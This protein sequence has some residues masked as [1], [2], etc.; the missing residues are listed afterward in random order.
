MPEQPLL[1]ADRYLASMLWPDDD[2]IVAIAK[3]RKFTAE[4]ESRVRIDPSQPQAGAALG[5]IAF[6]SSVISI[7]LTIAASFFKPRTSDSKGGITATEKQ[8]EN[9]IVANRTA[10]KVGFDSVQQ[11][12]SL[13]STIPV[14]WARRQTLPAQASPPRPAGTYGGIRVNLGL[15]WSQLVTEKGSQML[16][17]VFLLG[18]GP[19]ANLDTRGFAIGDNSLGTYDIAD[20]SVREAVSRATIYANLVG[21]AINGTHGYY[22]RHPSSDPGNSIN[23]GGNTVFAIKDA[24]NTYQEHFCYSTKPSTSTVFGLYAHIPNKM[25]FRVN[26]RIRPTIRVTTKSFDNGEKFRVD[27]DDDPQALADHWK[28]RYHYSM[29]SGIE[30]TSTGSTYLNTGD[31]FTYRLDRRSDAETKFRFNNNNTDNKSSESDGEASCGDV[32]SAISSKQKS[33]DEALIIGE[34]YRCGSCLAVLISK[35]PSDVIFVSDSDTAPYEG[36]QTVYYVFRVVTAGRIGI[37]TD[38]KYFNP[39]YSGDRIDPPEWNRSS[40]LNKLKIPAKY[41]TCSSFPQL[42][43]CAIANLILARSSRIFE[44]GIK[45]TVGIRINGFINLRD[46]PSLVRI[47][48]NA[49]LNNEGKTYDKNAKIGITSFQSGTIQRNETRISFFRIWIRYGG[50]AWESLNATWGIRGS[51]EDSIFNSIRFEMKTV[52]RW[53]VRFEPVSSWEL[54]NIDEIKQPFCIISN[55]SGSTNRTMLNDGI[56]VE[57]NGYVKER[58]RTNFNISVLDTSN[59]IGIPKTDSKS[60]ID[61]WAMVAEGFPY[62]EIQCTAQSGPEH[63]IVY[64]NT[65][66]ENLADPT[67]D[68]IA[69][70]GLNIF[71]STEFNQL[72]Q[73]SAYV[74]GGT[75]ARRLLDSDVS[76]S[77]NLFPDVLREYLTN[78]IYGV[79]SAIGDNLVDFQSFFDAADW[80]QKRRY[81]YDAADATRVN[82]LQYAADIAAFHLLELSQRGGKFALSPAVVFPEDGPVPVKALFTAGNIVEGT[83]RLQFLE[84]SERQPIRVSAKWREER[85]RV[86]LTSSGFFPVE[87]EVFVQETQQSDSSLIESVDLSA[88]CTNAEHAIDVCC[89]LIRMR[90]LV[91]HSI[92]FSTTPDGLGAGLAAGDYIKVAMDLSYYDQFSHGVI[93][94][95]GTVLTT[96]NDLLTE[97]VHEVTAWDGASDFIEDINITV[98]TSGNATPTGIV[99][100]KKTSS[101]D[102]R[103]YKIEKIS[104]SE[105]GTV[106]IE[107]VHHPTDANGISE[108]GK[109]WTTYQTDSNWM[110]EGNDFEGDYCSC[111]VITGIYTPGSVLTVGNVVCNS[112][113]ASAIGIQWYRNGS[114]IVGANATTYTYSTADVGESL[115]VDIVYQSPLGMTG[116]CR[117]YATPGT[118]LTSQIVLLLHMDGDHNTVS[119]VDSSSY[120]HATFEGVFNSYQGGAYTGCRIIRNMSRFGG[121]SATFYESVFGGPYPTPTFTHPTAF[122]ITAQQDFTIEGWIYSTNSSGTFVSAFGFTIE[123]IWQG[124]SLTDAAIRVKADYPNNAWYVNTTIFSTFEWHHIALVRKS[125]VVTLYIDGVSR[126]SGIAAFASTGT[127]VTVGKI[128]GFLDE[129][130]LTRENAI[131]SASFTPPSASFLPASDTSNTAESILF[132]MHCN[133][134]EGSTDLVNNSVYTDDDQFFGALTGVN[135]LTAAQSVFGGSSLRMSG[136]TTLGYYYLPNILTNDFT[137]DLWIRPNAKSGYIFTK[138]GTAQF[139]GAG[140]TLRFMA[141]NW[142]NSSNG[143]VVTVGAWNHIAVTREGLNTYTFVNGIL[144]NT[145]T[146][147]AIYSLVDNFNTSALYIGGLSYNGSPYNGYIDEFRVMT[148]KAEWTT[149]FTPPTQ[150]YSNPTN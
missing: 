140:N 121:S 22:G 68:S 70:V 104:V 10:P 2:P 32:A 64:V 79:G 120:E 90:R 15:I 27:C 16:R 52:R 101:T 56:I 42:F 131:Y 125:G 129:V 55:I 118:A 91:T 49:G 75:K 5:I 83:F 134:V 108:I 45:S 141:M 57:W 149:S 109:N 33:A 82:T 150:P 135:Y 12:S 28:A 65:I 142:E 84:E 29:R 19:I 53:E 14:V 47:N 35:T 13:G 38:S 67:Y 43:R 50:G 34:L 78:E 86:D 60:Y 132:L 31:L 59:D 102:V 3:Y 112:G 119:F 71:A 25:A 95:N 103:T 126:A 11:P 100:A 17:A 6:A 30:S 46:C 115:Y 127:T 81:F 111:P 89:Y 85:Q 143:A 26:P 99:F 21:G 136:T 94:D 76:G 87:R 36:G 114:V 4:I 105:E 63:E 148:G 80:C 39:D 69:T 23:Y 41:S 147:S 116:T 58:T 139:D 117:V 144:A 110:I 122:Q 128:G 97:G 93:L 9:I 20:Q 88:F 54:R 77:T 62:Q 74:T 96:R 8:G 92:S 40:S 51:S 1:P 66:S 106:D 124:S 130:R 18:E 145:Y 137:I 61:D 7:G 72:P 37:V 98:D 48:K 113:T 133:G 138:F 107:A 73:F 146:D 24:N 123:F 44:I